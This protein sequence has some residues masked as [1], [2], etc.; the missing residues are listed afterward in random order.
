MEVLAGALLT[1][2][3]FGYHPGGTASQLSF[4]EGGVVDVS[5][6]VYG[7][8]NLYVS[9]A[10]VATKFWQSNPMGAT[11]AIGLYAGMMAIREQ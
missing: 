11:F 4:N 9:D 3:S 2:I 7:T 10:S 6:R 8:N 1:T 5:M